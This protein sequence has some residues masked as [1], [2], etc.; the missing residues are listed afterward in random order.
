MEGPTKVT[1]TLLTRLAIDAFL[2]R[3][4]RRTA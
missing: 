2:A 3:I 4:G 1:D